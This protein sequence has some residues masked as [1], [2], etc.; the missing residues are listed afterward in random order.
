[1][2]ALHSRLVCEVRLHY[3]LHDFKVFLKIL[4]TLSASLQQTCVCTVLYF[5]AF[6]RMVSHQEILAVMKENGWAAALVGHQ[7]N[8][9]K[10]SFE[11]EE[12]LCA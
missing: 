2:R 3:T 5:A 8:A 7:L 1:M 6:W 10:G 11:E 12:L 4:R 9:L